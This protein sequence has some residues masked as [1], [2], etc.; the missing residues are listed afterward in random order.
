MAIETGVITGGEDREAGRTAPW[1]ETYVDGSAAAEKRAFAGFAREIMRVQRKN[2][3]S[4]AV[5]RA[6]H[7]KVT[8]A[9]DDARLHFR[10]DL[11][12]DLQAGFASPDADYRVMIRFSNA[13]G[14]RQPDWKKDL[15]GVA[16][17]VEVP[18]ERSHDLLMTNYP[19][20]HARSAHQFVKFATATAGGVSVVFGL[21]K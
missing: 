12:P 14:K 16:L 13:S 9:V 7:A 19:V 1:E 15:R 20:S 17:R 10:P 6:F 4:G 21:A 11:P 5:Y 18:L 3:P 2:R 8:L